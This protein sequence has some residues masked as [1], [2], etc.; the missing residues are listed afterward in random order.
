MQT[1][2]LL[3][4]LLL[5]SSFLVL[6]FLSKLHFFF[7]NSYILN[8]CLFLHRSIFLDAR[9][10]LFVQFLIESASLLILFAFEGVENVLRKMSVIGYSTD[11]V[12]V[13]V[14]LYQF[15]SVLD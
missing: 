12:A 1:R 11:L 7:S 8:Y 10:G 15:L 5:F 3:A 4:F 14:F 6:L 13:Y 9:I 2:L